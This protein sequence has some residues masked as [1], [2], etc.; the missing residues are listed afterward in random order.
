MVAQKISSSVMNTVTT[1][2]TL[3]M[4]NRRQVMMGLI[5]VA[6]GSIFFFVYR[7]WSGYRNQSAQL[8]LGSLIESYDSAMREKNQ[9]WDALVKKFQ[10][11]YE[12]NSASDLASYFLV[13]Q[14]ELLL[15]QG[16]KDEALTVLD[17]AIS[18]LGSASLA[19]LY[20][21]KRALIKLDS[22]DASLQKEGQSELEAL[23]H[24][25]TNQFNDSALFYL[26]R[27]YWSSD[28]TSA[29]RQTWQKL[30]DEHR[31][32][33]V[34]SAWVAQAKHYLEVTII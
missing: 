30:V 23:A 34:P 2:F 22:A 32:E 1:I 10:E 9:D 12:E 33:T 25:K 6:I 20:K 17:K 8:R 24:D 28:D 11:G 4:K 19:P 26:G 14:A 29:A 5:L 18:Q 7:M 15:S 27:Y 13:Y 3:I 21:M 16:K 31:D